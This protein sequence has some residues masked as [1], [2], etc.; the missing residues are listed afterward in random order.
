[1]A[2]CPTIIEVKVKPNARHSLLAQAEDGS[3]LA[4][5]KAAPVEGRA[6]AELIALVARHFGCTKAAVSIQAGAS[7]RRKRVKIDTG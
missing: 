4:Q 7:G 2:G 1:M 3:W 6:N 5:L